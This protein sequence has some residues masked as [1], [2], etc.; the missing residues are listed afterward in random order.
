MTNA[1]NFFFCNY[2]QKNKKSVKM[3]VCEGSQVL[4]SG[5][6]LQFR[7][8]EASWMV[9]MMMAECQSVNLLKN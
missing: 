6:L 3:N 5:K 8:K 1:D 7:T 2:V 9:M 4:S